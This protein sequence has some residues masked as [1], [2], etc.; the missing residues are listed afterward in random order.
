MA[1]AGGDLGASPEKRAGKL[2]G[3][4]FLLIGL[5]IG[6]ILGAL[7]LLGGPA[8]NASNSRRLPP[9]V[10]SPVKD[11]QL[12]AL[13]GSAVRLS[14]MQGKPVVINFWAT[15]CAPCE[16]EIPLLNQ[17][18]EKYDEQMTVLGVNYGET[19]QQIE[20]FLVETPVTFPIL[21]DTTNAVTDDY[22]VRSFPMTF[23]ID[24]EGVLR[25]QH[26]GMLSETLLARYLKTIG[27]EP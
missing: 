9:T 27:I 15:W 4:A 16:E 6:G 22:Y 26:L 13:D 5:L 2:K 3:V 19:K 11:F 20:S 23:F 1:E 17:Y 21:L 25:A 10:G 8:G 24:A 14:E 12:E 7:V 18:A